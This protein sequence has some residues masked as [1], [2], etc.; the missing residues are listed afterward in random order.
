MTKPQ[1]LDLV[2]D[3]LHD[4]A[5]SCPDRVVRFFLS[6]D[7]HA[8]LIDLYSPPRFTPPAACLAITWRC[9]S[10]GD[11]QQRKETPKVWAMGVALLMVLALGNADRL[12]A[13]EHRFTGEQVG[14]IQIFVNFE[15]EIVVYLCF[16]RGYMSLT[17]GNFVTHESDRCKEP[18]SLDPRTCYHSLGVRLNFF[19]LLYSEP[20]STTPNPYAQI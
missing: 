11:E 1:R 19:G 15:I 16:R 4:Q 13:N 2:L 8:S 14:G 17:H 6:N 20:L 7:P 10:S 12:V 5:P 9:C 3:V 18:V